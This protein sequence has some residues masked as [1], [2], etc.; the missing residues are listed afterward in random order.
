[1]A[2]PDA[3]VGVST[4]ALVIEMSSYGVSCSY[5]SSRVLHGVGGSTTSDVTGVLP[6]PW[7][8]CVPVG[9]MGSS[10]PGHPWWT[11]GVRLSAGLLH[12]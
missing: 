6:L 11:G 3:P 2:E 4:Y 10:M 5:S 12:V 8:S 9:P 1:M 7:V